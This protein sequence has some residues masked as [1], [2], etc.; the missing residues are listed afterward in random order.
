MKLAQVRIQNFPSIVDSG[1]VP[2][3]EHVTVIVGKNEQGKTNFFARR[4]A[5]GNL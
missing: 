5:S 3:D 2:I 4:E 1:E